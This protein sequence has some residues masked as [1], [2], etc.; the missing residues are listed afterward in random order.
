MIGSIMLGT[1]LVMGT[2]IVAVA[3]VIV[4][5]RFI[6]VLVS[7]NAHGSARIRASIWW[8]LGICLSLIL[9]LSLVTPLHS[10]SAAAGFAGAAVVLIALGYVLA[11]RRGGANRT[12][13]SRGTWALGISLVLVVAYLAYKALGPATNY[14]TGLYHLGAIKYAS[15]FQTIP[16]LAN[17]YTPFGYANGQFPMAAFLG[18][19]PWGQEGFRLLN[20]LLICLVA[21][22]LFLRIRSRKW[23]WGTFTLI[24]GVAGTL[25]PLIAIADFWVTSPT[26]DTAILLLTLVAVA[27]LCDYFGSRLDRALNCSVVLVAITIMIALRPTMVFFSATTL[28]V[29]ALAE[30][31]RTRQGSVSNTSRGFIAAGVL[32]LAL[33]GLQIA[34]DYV[35]SGW[36]MF[37]LSL[38]KFNVSWAASDPVNIRDATLAAARDYSTKDGWQTAHSWEW[39]PLW[40]SRLWS[41]WETYFFIL[42]CLLAIAALVA[43]HVA[44]KRLA[45]RRLIACMLPSI[46]AVIAWFTVSPPSYRFIWGP[47]FTIFLIPLGYGLAALHRSDA[48]ISTRTAP[49]VLAASC[50]VLLVVTGFSA[51]ARNQASTI[52]E[53]R[54]FQLGGVSLNYT[55]A[56]LPVVATQDLGM[57][58]GLVVRTPVSGDQCWN[59]YPLCTFNPESALGL[60]GSDLQDGFM[61]SKA[62]TP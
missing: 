23:S 53:S 51:F 54:E 21:V 31:I 3:L 19:G 27:Y 9:A 36:L 5:G 33:G 32:A 11:R 17:L 52:S 34:R 26:S 14:D 60:R 1:L 50:A 13:M 8:G 15:D 7:P 48:R 49:L 59:V 22:E 29:L 4:I 61:I 45:P 38:H 6:P 57:S 39:I 62:P 16:G 10:G 41:Q 37:P 18:N 46:V 47:L 44:G 25:I 42:G 30:F 20:G 40:F 43:A 24:A 56:P 12:T 58:T 35:L 2:W 55:V 28:L